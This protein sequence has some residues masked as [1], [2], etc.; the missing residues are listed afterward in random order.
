MAVSVAVGSSAVL[1]ALMASVTPALAALSV[2]AAH[3]YVAAVCGVTNDVPELTYS[4]G[5]WYRYTCH[6]ALRPW[7]LVRR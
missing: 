4:N 3:R 7:S 1:V 2:P 5:A 6:S